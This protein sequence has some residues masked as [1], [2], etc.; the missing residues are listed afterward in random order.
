MLFVFIALKKNVDINFDVGSNFLCWKVKKRN[1][2]TKQSNIKKKKKREK[3]T[4]T[5]QQKENENIRY[6]CFIYIWMKVWLAAIEWTTYSIYIGLEL[7]LLTIFLFVP[8]CCWDCCFYEH[9][10][11][12]VRFVCVSIQ[13]Q[14]SLSHFRY[15]RSFL[16]KLA[17]VCVC[18]WVWKRQ[19]EK[20]F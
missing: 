3:E 8:M 16:S 20:R 13:F 18:V 10:S 14:S 7:K 19:R 15:V 9:I 12:H 4:S 2:E 11:T 6:T 5:W 17:Y 1:K